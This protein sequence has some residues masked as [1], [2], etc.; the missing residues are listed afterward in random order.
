[1]A[2]KKYRQYWTAAEEASPARLG[3]SAS[4]VPLRFQK[5]LEEGHG[6]TRAHLEDVRGDSERTGNSSD[7]EQL[8]MFGPL[9][10]ESREAIE[11]HR[12]WAPSLGSHHRDGE[13]EWV[14]ASK[15][16]PR[17]KPC[18][19]PGSSSMFRHLSNVSVASGKTTPEGN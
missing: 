10:L 8:K 6:E 4:G 19:E 3:P 16:M 13:S 14:L 11:T 17:G 12:G 2:A 5:M 15:S 7:K 18:R 1:M 9:H